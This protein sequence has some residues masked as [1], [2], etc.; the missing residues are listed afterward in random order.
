MAERDDRPRELSQ[1]PYDPHDPHD[2]H[3][4]PEAVANRRIRRTALWTYLG[5]I[6]V[7]AVILGIAMLFWVRHEPGR[8][9]GER[10]LNPIGTTGATPKDANEAQYPQSGGGDPARRPAN[11]ADELKEKGAGR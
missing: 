6:V 4:P 5:P 7:L 10:S 9:P 3:D 1:H 2:P 11:T 8:A